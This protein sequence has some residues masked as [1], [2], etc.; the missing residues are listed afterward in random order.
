MA[1]VSN[2]CPEAK[3]KPDFEA[4]NMRYIYLQLI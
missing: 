4:F 2:I 1:E 3:T